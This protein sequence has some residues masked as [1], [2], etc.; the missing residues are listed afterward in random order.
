[1]TAK[2]FGNEFRKTFRKRVILVY[3]LLVA[4]IVI[5]MSSH[6]QLVVSACVRNPTF[7]SCDFA[8][9]LCS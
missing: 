1:M 5:S 2:F 4:F 9:L 7:P 3:W 8:V 6:F